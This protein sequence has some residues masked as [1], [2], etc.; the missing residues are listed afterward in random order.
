MKNRPYLIGIFVIFIVS[1][2]VVFFLIFNRPDEPV[3]SADRTEKSESIST[4]K[5][6]AVNIYFMDKDGLFLSAESRTVPHAESAVPH[7]IE[8]QFSFFW[9]LTQLD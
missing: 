6:A 2:G 3:P 1:A 9:T 8:F 7:T 5:G 4:V